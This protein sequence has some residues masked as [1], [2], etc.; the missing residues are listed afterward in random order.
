MDILKQRKI[1]LLTSGGDAPGMNAAIRAVVRAALAEK[2]K[3]I[4]FMRG[5]EG[6]ISSDIVE[7]ESMSVSDIIHRGGTILLTAR[8]EDM[9]TEAGQDRAARV[10]DVLGLEALVVIGGDGSFRGALELKKRGVNVYGIPATIDLDIDCTEYTIGF[11]TAVNT[12]M[13]A[14]TRIRDTSSSHERCSVVEVMGRDCGNIA[15][16]CGMTGGAEEALIP[17]DETADTKT[18]I[19]EIIRNRSRGK[20]H[21]LIIIAEGR[22]GK[23]GSEQL[24]REIQSITGINARATILGH[25][26]RGGNPSALDRMR[27]SMMGY[28]AVE[29]FMK[30]VRDRVIIYKDGK[31][32]DMDFEEA[33][34]VK[35]EYNREIYDIMKKLS[36]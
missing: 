18:V 35:R 8:S 19:N 1:G 14:I 3:V 30:G 12:G 20:R 17:E 9:M 36:I 22:G 31:Y 33:L 7:L 4:G 10:C 16:W 23:G 2:I 29:L 21:N 15:L 6:L 25:L 5:Y 28:R 24:A 11:D 32:A 26:Q 13:E 27:A 34:G